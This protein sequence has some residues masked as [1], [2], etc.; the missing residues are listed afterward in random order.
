MK[1][2]G[3]AGT[4]KSHRPVNEYEF[5]YMAEFSTAGRGRVVHNDRPSAL[6]MIICVD[7]KKRETTASRYQLG[8]CFSVDGRLLAESGSPLSADW[9]PSR[10]DYFT[11][12]VY[13]QVR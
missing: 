6:E 8:H 5:R 7:E 4:W 13:E 2:G 12:F 11:G 3:G 9:P 1:D 10:A